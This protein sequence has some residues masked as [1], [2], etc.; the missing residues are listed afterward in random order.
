MCYN[1]DMNVF[2]IILFTLGVVAAFGLARAAILYLK[3]FQGYQFLKKS[4][5]LA[6][7][8]GIILIAGLFSVFSGMI[9]LSNETMQKAGNMVISWITGTNEKTI[10]EVNEPE[11]SVDKKAKK[12]VELPDSFGEVEEKE[13]AG[14]TEEPKNNEQENK[15]KEEKP[16]DKPEEKPE[17]KPTEKPAPATEMPAP[18]IKKS[19]LI[20]SFTVWSNVYKGHKY[21]YVEVE[22]GVPYV[23]APTFRGNFADNINN[24]RLGKEG[25]NIVLIANAGIF[26]EVDSS[27]V[28][29]AIQN[30]S[31]V[32]AK[33][34]DDKIPRT[35]VID[36]TGNVGYTNKAIV[37]G[38]TSYTDAM[39]GKTIS[40]RKI[41]SAVTGFT[42]VVI[43]GKA[44]TEYKTKIANYSSYRARS[45]FCVRKN[46]AYT[47]ITNTG[48]GIDG[49]GWNFDDMTTIALRRGC[50]F[51]FNF[52]GGGSTAL[53]WRT[54]LSQGFTTYATTVRRDPTYI[55]FT[56]D[57]RAPVGK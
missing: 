55:V 38:T 6:F 29:T 30:G 8:L 35:L 40:G 1:V 50:H 13:I 2:G 39:T 36:E 44:A 18:V 43:N 49:G 7:N 5:K 12:Q 56:A 45:M 17:E 53:A 20:P 42:P 21:A 24:I 32:V 31:V 25:K 28:G 3:T 37:N 26:N 10:Q 27:P 19:T 34:K 47:I 54:S 14:K 57:N 46:N 11:N 51:A 9:F 33:T 48:E 41:V 52:D 23:Y 16:E 15:P 22:N 4:Q